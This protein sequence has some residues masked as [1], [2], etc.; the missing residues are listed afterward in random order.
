VGS[1]HG[2]ASFF[3]ICSIGFTSYRL[4]LSVNH[5]VL[6]PPALC[7]QLFTDKAWELFLDNSFVHSAAALSGVVIEYA[8][9]RWS[10]EVDAWGRFGIHG[11]SLPVM[12]A[13]MFCLVKSEFG[14]DRVCQHGSD[15]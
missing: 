4:A 9:L 10:E 8:R 7:T 1:G 11:Y 5:A 14:M 15:R 12:I 3:G 6:E 13:Q 2:G